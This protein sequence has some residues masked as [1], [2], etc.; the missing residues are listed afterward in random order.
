MKLLIVDD[1][2]VL[3]EGLAALLR[4]SGPDTVILQAADAAEGLQLAGANPE[5][6]LVVLDLVLQGMSGLLAIAEFGRIR[7]DLPVIV[8]SSSEDPQDARKALAEGA[9]G[10]VPK[11]ASQHTLMSAIAIVLNGDVYVPPLILHDVAGTH[12]GRHRRK[13]FDGDP[14]LTDRQIDVLRR[15][16]QGQPNKTIA[17]DLELSEKTVK[18]HITAIFKALDVVNRTQ[19]ATVG[20]EAGLI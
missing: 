20:R 3:R 12:Q 4:Q 8:L 16:S 15:I 13:G 11:S 2:P 6:D 17:F 7:P 1:H 5:L 14:I 10:Y 9:L 18:A 19:A